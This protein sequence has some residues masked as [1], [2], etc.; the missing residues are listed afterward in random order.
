MKSIL[1]SHCIEQKSIPDCPGIL[2]LIYLS[3]FVDIHYIW[4][5][6]AELLSKAEWKV[7][8]LVCSWHFEFQH[9]S[10]LSVP[11]NWAFLTYFSMQPKPEFKLLTLQYIHKHLNL[12]CSRMWAVQKVGRALGSLGLGLQNVRYKF[13]IISMLIVAIQD[14]YQY[15][16]FQC[17]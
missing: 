15:R 17:P 9:F 3:R 8:I 7:G 11:E 14:C 10:V 12:S 2:I 1:L 13:V 6:Q 4:W 5:N 16:Q